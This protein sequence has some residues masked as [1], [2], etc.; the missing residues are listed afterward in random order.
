MAVLLT[1]GASASAA[2]PLYNGATAGL[3]QNQGWVTYYSIPGTATETLAA[4]NVGPV[5]INTN[6]LA[7]EHAGLSNYNISGNLV[8]PAFPA[9]SRS[10]GFDLTFSAKL[11]LESHTST[12][13]AGF[14]VILLSSDLQ[15]IELGFWPNEVWGQSANASNGALD[16]THAEGNTAFNTSSGFHDYDLHIQNSAYTLF[17]DGS[18]ILTG[19]T[20]DYSGYPINTGLPDPYA[21]PNYL[22]F[23]DDTSSAQGAFE[24]N[25]VAITP[26]PEPT[27]LGLLAIA[28]IATLSRRSRR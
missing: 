9:L 15:G 22:F 24:L 19:P 6:A 2:I 25:N 8:N 4:G 18:Q 14:S 3:P 17:A 11:D 16:F 7:Q 1:F 23:G 10:T 12:D 27:T 13:R 20:R 5:T 21:I 26:L 28:G